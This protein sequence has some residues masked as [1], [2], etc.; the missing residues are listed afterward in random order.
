MLKIGIIGGS[1]LDNPDILKDPEKLEITTEYGNPSSSLL[2]GKINGIETI[3]IARHGRNHQYSPTQVN[4]RANIKA[5]QQAEV[6]H[7]IAT[8]ACGSL[9]HEID[10]G[11]L[12]VLD[13]FIDF[14]RFRKNTFAD[15]FENGLVHPVMAHPFDEGLRKKLYE[16]AKYLDLNV[17]D[18][19]C[20]VT[21]EGPR[22]STV[23]ESK[24]FKI[25]GA[26]VINMSTAPEAMLANEA[27]IPYAAVAMSTDYDC[28]KEDE[29]PVTWEE[30]L[31][32]FD[33]NAHNVIKL[34]VNVIEE[35]K[36]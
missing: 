7:I 6:T 22:F 29:V 8:T 24:M 33:Q 15:S 25:W 3:I 34:L 2:T 16:T 10:R 4:N 13:Q 35:L 12:V 27:G 30:I 21:I 23:A 26:D 32:V 20:V 1:G 36:E 11:H 5:L 18:K 17:H 14:T 9:R 19:G 28:W 31:A